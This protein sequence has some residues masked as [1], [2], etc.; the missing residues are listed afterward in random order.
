MG[1]SRETQTSFAASASA[2]GG[3]ASRS[4]TCPPYLAELGLR[5]KSSQVSLRD[6]VSW[7]WGASSAADFGR[8]AAPSARGR[9]G[10]ERPRSSA[11]A[12]RAAVVTQILGGGFPRSMATIRFPSD[13]GA[14]WAKT[15]PSASNVRVV[16]MER[17]AAL[18]EPKNRKPWNEVKDAEKTSFGRIEKLTAKGEPTPLKSEKPKKSQ[19]S[20][21]EPMEETDRHVSIAKT[22]KSDQEGLSPSR[23]KT[24]RSDH[25]VSPVSRARTDKSEY[26]FEEYSPTNANTEHSDV[27][28]SPVSRAR[29]D[30]SDQ[31]AFSPSRAKTDR[32]AVSP[33]SR[34]RTDKSEYDFEEYSPTNAN[35]EHSDAGKSPVSLARTDK[36]HQEGLSPSRAKTDRSAVSPVSRARTDKSEYD[37]EEYSPT[38][39]NTEHS[40][41]G[42]SPVSRARTDKSDQIRSITSEQGE[43]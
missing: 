30:K 10:R 39:A 17:L 19:S 27:G 16:S 41:V 29:T 1:R 3:A 26:D 23:A 21:K 40:D 43:N 32:S 33:V 7:A 38:N 11:A 34:A 36:S 6:R 37:F 2:R 14:S 5:R 25:A 13:T 24:D 12:T 8:L 28:K 9:D 35:T 4:A 18:A 42:K 22:D 15:K 20:S 31:E